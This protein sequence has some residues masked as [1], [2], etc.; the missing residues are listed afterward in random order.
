MKN[1]ELK[2]WPGPFKEIAEGRKN[3]EYRVNDREFEIGDILTLREFDPKTSLYT[4]YQISRPVNYILKGNT[5]F[6]DLGNMCIMS[7]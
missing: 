2:C 1:H 7:I 5:P 4:G 6:G 3:F